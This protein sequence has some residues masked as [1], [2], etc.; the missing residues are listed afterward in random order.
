MSSADIVLAVF[1]LIGA[2][3]G[4]RQ[5]FLMA[6]FS[7]AALVLGIIGAFKLLGEAMVWLAAQFDISESVLPY[8]AFA[9]VFIAILIAVILVGKIIK[10]SID[11]TFLGRVDQA[12]GSLLGI[13]KAAFLLSVCLW[14]LDVLNLELPSSWA[15][16]S[17]LLPHVEAFAP[18]V[19]LWLSEFLP[20]FSDVFT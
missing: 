16:G 20:F 14:I 12:A 11:K 8:V 19:A 13:L 6:L 9:V 5:G 18:M 7:L 3:S 1:L 4:Y 17:W 10:I 2:V 15:E